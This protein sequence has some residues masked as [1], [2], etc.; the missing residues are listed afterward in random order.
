MGIH[1]SRLVRASAVAALGAM[2][3][4]LGGARKAADRPNVDWPAYGGVTASRYSELAQI[5][6]RTVSALKQVWRFDTGKGGLQTS[7]LVMGR[8]LYAYTPGQQVI[9]LEATTGR[10]RWTFDAKFPARQPARGPTWWSDGKERRLFAGVMNQ[11]YALDPDTGKPITS[12]GE[13]G[14]VD[15]RKELGND[16]TQNGV[17]LTSP[18][19]IYK[20]LII[21]GFRTGETK[22]AAPGHIRAYDVH[23]GKLRWI[24][25][26]IPQPGE[27]GYETWP[28]EAWKT[29]G[30]ANNWAGMVVDRKRGIV[31]VPTGSAVDDMY[32]YDRKGDDLYADTLLALN[33]ATGKQL[34]RFQGVHHDMW[35]R[36]FPSPPVLVTVARG[37][38]RIDA[39]AQTTKQGFVFVFDRASGKPLFP[40]E[41]RRFE[42]STVPGEFSSPT[43]P[44]PLA[45]EPFA[46]QR[47]TSDMLTTRTPEAH[48]FAAKA[49]AGMYSGGP[50]TPLQLD[51]PTIVFPGFDG[52]AEWGGPAVDPDGVLYVNANDV[53]WT[54]SITKYDPSKAAGPGADVYQAAC[55]SCHGSDREGSP[56]QFPSLLGIGA[57]MSAKEIGDLLAT[58]RG[59]MPA[60]PLPDEY[61]RPL[62]EYLVNN[63]ATAPPSPGS[64]REAQNPVG[65][66][67]APYRFTGYKK[68]LDPDGYP[69]IK[70]PW[71]TLNAIDL[72]TGRY[73]WKTPLGEYPELADKGLRDT[74]SEN[75]GGPIVTAGGLVIIGATNFDHKIRAFDR[76]TGKLIWR[77]DLPFSGNATPMT[78]MID[79]RQYVVIATSNARNPKGP[80][81]SAYVAFALPN[82]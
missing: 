69:A 42:A 70:P 49:F 21:V 52:G 1:R 10:L 68:F 12:F 59:R 63:G 81:G 15:L 48:E 56:P 25:H 24:F 71:G 26:T 22:P 46:R 65:Q 54:G 80:A 76:R 36:D 67:K 62:I 19:V 20:D 51:K 79:R 53:A 27:P 58:G 30:G 9:A 44:V 66:R 33:A 74:G 75:Y 16:Y 5:N 45:P 35:D 82:R 38:K 2:A 55:A 37:A 6:T 47:L 60:L 57:R 40:I 77:A 61:K 28:V 29:A 34:W 17:V 7:P 78:Y 64:D 4:V 18:G 3:L 43:Q 13:G 72:N 14:K 23:T 8:T 50:Y 32:G 41:E 39:V 31:F 11:L 73:L